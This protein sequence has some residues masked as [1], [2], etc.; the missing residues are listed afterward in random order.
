MHPTTLDLPATM[1]AL[2]HLAQRRQLAALGHGRRIVDHA[3]AAGTLVPVRPGWVATPAASQSA[4][5]AVLRGA[6]VTG[7]T[8]LRSHGIWSGSD[9]RLY[10]QLPSN[11]HRIRQ[12]PLTPVSLFVRPRFPISGVVTGWTT[13]PAAPATHAQWRVPVADALRHFAR[14]E[15]PEQVVAAVESA[16][17]LRRLSRTDACTLLSR[18]PRRLGRLARRANFHAE[19]GLESIG[20]MRLEDLEIAGRQQVWIGQDRVDLLIDNWLVIEWDGDEWHDPVRDRIRTNRL[21]RAGYRVLRFGYSDVF[22]RWP[23]TV[24]TILELL[25]SGAPR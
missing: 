14:T 16:E 12:E 7:A 3:L 5:I 23:E 13:V 10:L 11:A 9:S 24:A 17:H 18:L 21:I 25:G 4:V 6:R 20:R 8:A 19:S 2:G 22:S 15:P 1:T